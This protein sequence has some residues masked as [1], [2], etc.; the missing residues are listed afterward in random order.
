MWQGFGVGAL[1]FLGGIGQ[2]I[3]NARQAARNRAFQE[4]MTRNRYQY[5]M[6]D[7]RKAGLNPMLAFS[8]G[9]GSAPAGSTAQI[10][11]PVPDA[12]ATGK[13]AALAG[14][15]RA[16]LQA[17]VEKT[18]ADT[19]TAKAAE[20]VSRKQAD[21]IDA[22]IAGQRYANTARQLENSV[23]QFEVDWLQSAA[24]RTAR[25][26]DLESRGAGPLTKDMSFGS[27]W[28]N[29]ALRQAMDSSTA[30]QVGDQAERAKR[31]DAELQ[32]RVSGKAAEFEA[33]LRSQGREVRDLWQRMKKGSRT[34]HRSRS[35]RKR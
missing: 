27:R 1:S 4:R 6:E 20:A 15:E 31:A 21:L 9:G 18:K 23:K 17:G 16:A 14:S 12:V 32:R 10:G 33:W 7:M 3:A 28:L 19:G 8:Q 29:D 2:N 34:Q 11:N 26:A 5:T 24:G 35:G 13:Q 22:Q 30:R 25:R